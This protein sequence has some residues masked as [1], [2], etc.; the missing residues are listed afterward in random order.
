MTG[1]STVLYV[2]LLAHFGQLLFLTLVENPHIFRTYGKDRHLPHL[3][4]SNPEHVKVFRYYFSRDLVGFFRNMDLCRAPDL[5]TLMIAVYAVV[6]GLFGTP[7]Y[8]VGQT[9]AW[10]LFHTGILGYIL[11]RQ[12]TRKAWT[13]HFI[14]FGATNKEAFEHWKAIYNLSI[15]MLYITFAIAA[16]RNYVLPDAWTVQSVTLRHVLGSVLILLH[17]WTSL[18]VFEVLGEFGYFYGDFFIDE[19]PSQLFYTGIYRFI[20]NPEKIMGHAAFWGI[21]IM[22]SSW[23]MFAVTLFSQAVNLAFIR[24]VEEPHMHKLYGNQVRKDSGLTKM[25]KEKVP[26]APKLTDHVARVVKDATPHKLS[27]EV[28]SAVLPMKASLPAAVESITTKISDIFVTVPGNPHESKHSGLS[29]DEVMKYCLD[30]PIDPIPFGSPVKISFLAPATRGLRDWIAIYKIRRSISRG[31]SDWNISSGTRS[32]NRTISNQSDQFVLDPEEVKEHHAIAQGQGQSR[33]RWLSLTHVSSNGHWKYLNNAQD[34]PKGMDEGEVRGEVTFEDDTLIWAT[35][36]YEA[37]LHYDDTHTVVA[38]SPPFRITVSNILPSVSRSLT[39][40]PNNLTESDSG[41]SSRSGSDLE[42]DPEIASVQ[43]QLNAPRI[44]DPKLDQ[45]VELVR[46]CHGSSGAFLSEDLI[47]AMDLGQ[48]TTKIQKR[49]ISALHA[50]YDIEF[51]PTALT[52]LGTLEALMN[53]ISLARDTLL[54]RNRR[55]PSPQ[56]NPTVPH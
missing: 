23:T 35:G 15:S 1:S 39:Q 11:Y 3:I 24:L 9:I 51:H 4:G 29:Q 34:A 21:T 37:R 52:Q 32:R 55:S 17:I 30:A 22:S 36:L 47:Q 6:A 42:S 45:L 12:S 41:H 40:T 50:R 56:L 54:S 18:S 48:L 27:N 28:K 19:I 14:R 26:L 53:R 25:V 8:A 31:D 46:V 2:S 13:R 16:W 38:I 10:I 44:P 43:A 20:N 7:Q 33:G 49:M 5:F